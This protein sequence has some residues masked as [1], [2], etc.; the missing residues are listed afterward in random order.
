MPI[1]SSCSLPKKQAYATPP[2]DVLHWTINVDL[3]EHELHLV[4]IH[5]KAHLSFVA[6]NIMTRK[7]YFYDSLHGDAGNHLNLLK[8]LFHKFATERVYY[9][10]NPSKWVDFCPKPG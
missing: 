8:S 9:E 1:N 3:F 5:T 10:E 7:L 4:P 6:I 2:K